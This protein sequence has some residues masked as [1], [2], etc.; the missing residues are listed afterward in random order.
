[1]RISIHRIGRVLSLSVLLAL[2]PA[3]AWAEIRGA[4]LMRHPREAIVTWGTEL[5]LWPLRGGPPATLLKGL[6][7]G[8]GGCVADVDGDGRDDLL[9]QETPQAGRF[10][11]LRAPRWESRVIERQTEFRDC[12]PF[13]FDGHRGVVLA[14]FDA[15]VR[16]YEFPKRI[17]DSWEYNELYSIYTAS[18]QGGLLACDVDGDGLTDLFIGNYWMRNPGRWDLPW[19]LFNMNTFFDKPDSALARQ[20]LFLRPGRMHPDLIWAESEGAP[21][22]LA[23]LERP[24]DE[25]QQWPAHLIEPA[26]DHPRALLVTEPL[27]GGWPELLVG[28]D[29]GVRVY[30]Y[31]RGA[32]TMSRLW[33]GA[34]VL[35]LFRAGPHTL[36]AVTP[37]GIRRIRLAS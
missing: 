22:R 6:N 14:H 3:S 36:L 13:E 24:A 30:R 18:R 33:N 5:K 29:D 12:L 15:Q 2:V 35:A 11:W 1:M 26:P 32:W 4:A 25:K 19:R 23:W 27:G 16:F 7:F 17:D 34:P 20:A 9:V 31:D 10:L 21:A 8:P 37:S 28:A